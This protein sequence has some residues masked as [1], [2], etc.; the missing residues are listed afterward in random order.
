MEALTKIEV[1]RMQSLMLADGLDKRAVTMWGDFEVVPQDTMALPDGDSVMR[2]ANY[3]GWT[4]V[5]EG[6]RDYVSV[7]TPGDVLDFLGEN[8]GKPVTFLINTPGG[9]VFGGTEI[10]NLILGHDA[11]TCAIVTGIAASVGSLI[12]AA[13]TK[14]EMMEAS[15]V[16]V[17]GPQT[18]AYGAAN[19]FREVADRLDK[20]AK[21]VAPIYKRRMDSDE[22]DRMLAEGDHYMTADEAVKSGIADGI[23]SDPSDGDDGGDDDTAKMKDPDGKPEDGTTALLK[24]QNR[25]RL[26]F[27]ATG[28]LNQE[29]NR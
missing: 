2:I 11:D 8:K 24:K 16:M 27:L 9:S 25:D 17:H 28:I 12:T 15:M 29:M 1:R 18:F 7:T 23:Y 5:A 6:N 10:A 13:C 4:D 14:V 21:A 22:V 26:S 19:D 3:I 20:E